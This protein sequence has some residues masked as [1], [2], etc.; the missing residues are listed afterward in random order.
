[1]SQAGAIDRL[2]LPPAVPPAAEWAVIEPM[3]PESAWEQAKTADQ[4]STAA[5][6]FPASRL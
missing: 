2:N 4:V 1:L 6:S 3:L 5:A